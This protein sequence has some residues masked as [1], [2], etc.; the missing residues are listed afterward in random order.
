LIYY[1]Y[2]VMGIN[3]KDSK[4]GYGIAVW[5]WGKYLGEEGVKNGITTK[6][7]SFS[8]HH[9]NVMMT[10]AKATGNY[11]N[12]TLAKMEAIN[13]GYDEAI[14]LDTQG[15]VAECSGENLFVVRNGKICTP[16]KTAI[17]EG[18]TRD[19]VIQIAKDIGIEVIEEQISRDQLYIADEVFLCGTAAEVTPVRMVD[20]REIGKPGPITKK[21]QEIFQKAVNGEIKKYET[22]L[23]Y[24]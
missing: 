18:I 7:S 14:L 20:K 5:K 10:K 8:R 22:W 6:I 9:V 19:S 3:V 2:G 24:I 4:V 1:D 12:S 21:I 13:D 23:S 15:F 16:P 17:L 11:T